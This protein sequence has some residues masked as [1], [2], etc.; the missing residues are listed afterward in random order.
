[1]IA[2]LENES[3][4]SRRYAR[5]Y[6]PESESKDLARELGI[7]YMLR[8]DPWFRDNRTFQGLTNGSDILPSPEVVPL[9][10]Q[11][12]SLFRLE[13]AFP[14]NAAD[15]VEMIP[16][17]GPIVPAP[18]ERQAVRIVAREQD[19]HRARRHAL[20]FECEVAS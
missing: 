18:P 10:L 2:E 19:A 5:I 8:P 14:G 15:G 17:V 6:R 11:F 20:R 4:K 16:P 3:R 9:I 13:F 12:H 1:M 7:R